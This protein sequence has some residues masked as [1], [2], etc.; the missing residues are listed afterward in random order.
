MELSLD[1]FTGQPIKVGDTI[2]ILITSCIQIYLHTSN[3]HIQRY[4]CRVTR[5]VY[6]L[7]PNDFQNYGTSPSGPHVSWTPQMFDSN[8]IRNEMVENQK[9][10]PS[11][12]DGFMI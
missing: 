8:L 7:V 9:N 2:N 5:R 3:F 1:A 4:L 10:I 11:E 12:F 6:V